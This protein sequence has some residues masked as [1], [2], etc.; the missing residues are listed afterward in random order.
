LVVEDDADVRSMIVRSLEK[1]TWDVIE[2]ADGSEGL[3]QLSRKTPTLILLDL[4]MP[5]MDGFEFLIEMRSNKDWRNL[6]VIVLTSK[7]LTR[8]DR[9]K[10]SGKVEQ[11]VQKE[12]YSGDQVTKLVQQLVNER[13]G[14]ADDT[15]LV[16]N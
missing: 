13:P 16:R 7:D 10:L 1:D 14:P 2:A 3:E 12:S 8:A 6:P 5:V 4:M 11:I 15:T 9:R